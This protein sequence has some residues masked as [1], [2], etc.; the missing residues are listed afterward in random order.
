MKTRPFAFRL[1]PAPLL[2]LALLAPVP[3]V[4]T[5]CGAMGG[6]MSPD[7]ALALLPEGVKAAASNYLGG[8]TDVT[9]LLGGLTNMAGAQSALP[10]LL[11]SINKIGDANKVLG[12][13]DAGTKGNVLSAFGPQLA[14]ANDGFL[15][16]LSRINSDPGLSGVLGGALKQIS[17]FK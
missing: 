9:K 14:E 5:G 13:L 11:G 15:G 3:F 8:L 10:K 6:A 17:L 12:G 1:V 2:A 4:L 7:K 16:Q